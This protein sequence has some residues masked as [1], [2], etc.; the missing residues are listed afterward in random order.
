MACRLLIAALSLA[1]TTAQAHAASLLDD[2]WPAPVINEGSGE[3]VTMR[4]HTPFALEDVG[5]G[6]GLDPPRDVNA[7]FYLPE[8]ASPL[9]KAPAVVL[10]HGSAGILQSRELTYGP[11]YAAMGVAALVVDTFGSRR[12]IATAYVDRVL[13]ITETTMVADAYAAL[14]WLAARPDVDARKVALMGFSYGALATLLAAYEQPALRFAPDG[15]RFAAHV[16]YYG[17]C[18]AKFEDSRATGAPILMLSAEHDAVTDP[19]RCADAADELRRGGTRVEQLRYDGA[20]HQWDGNAGGP[21]NPV[22]RASNLAA[23]R[24]NVARDGTVRDAKSGLEMSNAFFRKII[25]GLCNDSNGYLQ[26]RNDTVR[27]RSNRDVGRFLAAA[28]ESGA[29]SRAPKP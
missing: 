24:F 10:L 3:D 28:F 25:L 7:T 20:Y 23:C 9:R 29:P 12:D 22:R 21:D 17:P 18:L 27:L 2:P 15:L 4:S 1:C 5:A 6:P 8:G 14:R 19:K 26:A 11:Q 13:R 16:T